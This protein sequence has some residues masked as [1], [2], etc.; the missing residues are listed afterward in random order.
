MEFEFERSRSR[1]FFRKQWKKVDFLIVG[2]Q[3]GGTTALDHYLREHP[4]VGMARGRKELHFFDDEGIFA[5]PTINYRKLES[6]FSSS[7]RF[8][9]RGEATPSYL[10]W[11]PSI[12]RIHDYNSA[13]KLIVLLRNPIDRA[14]SH[15]NMF[16]EKGKETRQFMECVD[17][18]RSL[19]ASG[20]IGQDLRNS[21]L[22]RGIYGPQLDRLFGVFPK[23]QL[24]IMKYED[25][26]REQL[27]S[28][29]Q[30]FRFLGVETEL[31]QFQREQVHARPHRSRLTDEER[32]S[33]GE[34][35]SSDIECVERMLGWDCS[36]W[37]VGSPPALVR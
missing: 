35:F 1:V 5:H 21:Y 32:R 23:E 33:V 28:L 13:M 27:D 8:K 14:F 29:H 37:K 19:L 31:F 9:I 20:T 30:I 18:G 22:D 26:V 25:F 36:D 16:V 15:W 6:R 34:V 17:I 7:A 2:T 24:C 11:R 3:K 10:Y 4:E 12:Q